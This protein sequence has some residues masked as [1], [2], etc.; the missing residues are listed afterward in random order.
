MNTF[1]VLLVGLVSGAL[2][3]GVLGFGAAS[4]KDILRGVRPNTRNRFLLFVARP[5]SEAR[6]W[7]A[8]AF[9]LLIIA[10]LAVFFGLVLMPGVAA[11]RLAGEG[12]PLHLYAYGATAVA[13]WLGSKFGAHVWRTLT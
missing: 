7:E 13:W 12:P 5:T 6:G 4:H 3:G 11:E 9:L 2:L 1:V 8:I 10:W